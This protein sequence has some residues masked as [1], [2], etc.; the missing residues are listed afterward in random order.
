MTH[1]AT[2]VTLVKLTLQSTTSVTTVSQTV[3]TMLRVFS[4]YPQ[5]KGEMSIVIKCD[6][7]GR[8]SQPP[9]ANWNSAELMPEGWDECPTD[10]RYDWCPWC[11]VR[12]GIREE[13][14]YPNLPFPDPDY[15]PPIKKKKSSAK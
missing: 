4:M 6:E 2:A 3:A 1:A 5:R 11:L 14:D 12:F 7:C 15:T 10:D 9:Y 8:L 13:S